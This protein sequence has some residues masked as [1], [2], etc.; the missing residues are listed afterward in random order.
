MQKVKLDNQSQVFNNKRFDK[1]YSDIVSFNLKHEP[2]LLNIIKSFKSKNA[3]GP[4]EDKVILEFLTL[5]L[6]TN[7]KGPQ[8]QDYPNDLQAVFD[9]YQSITKQ[10]ID[11]LNLEE[12]LI[13]KYVSISFIVKHSNDIGAI[14]FL[15]INLKDC[16]KD[17]DYA[18]SLMGS[19]DLNLC[20][21]KRKKQ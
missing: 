17:R 21:D 8:F 10:E 20:L 2:E 18:Q 1:R 11:W 6:C 16:Q 15:K 3:N 9:F 13:L 12:F 14:E 19:S 4:L 5:Q 7:E